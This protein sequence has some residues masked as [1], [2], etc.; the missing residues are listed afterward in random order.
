[1][2]PLGWISGLKAG[3]LKAAGLLAL[4][5]LWGLCS[6]AQVPASLAQ[7]LDQGLDGGQG[8]AAAESAEEGAS[9]GTSAPAAPPAQSVQPDGTMNP[10]WTGLLERLALEG[11]NR[12]ALIPLF[13]NSSLVPDASI[14]GRKLR[15]L[16]K[17]RFLPKPEPKAPTGKPLTIYDTWLTPEWAEKI[18]AFK[19]ANALVLE[20]AARRYGTSPS[21]LTAIFLVETHLGTFLG[22]RPVL[23]ALAN[24]AA[25]TDPG[26]MLPF[27]AE[28]QPTPEQL[29]W[30]AGRQAEKSAW[31]LRQI[32]FF[33]EYCRLNGFA[34]LSLPGSLYGA[35]GLCQFTPLN[36]LRLGVDGD[37]DGR[38]DL[39]G[40]ADAAH[41]MGRFLKSRGWREDLSYQA[42]LKI[43][44]QYNNDLLY[45]QTVLA[46]AKR[47]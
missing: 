26:A 21:L 27:V 13:A 5:V 8:E 18:A 41:S 36:A 3:G 7:G 46:V 10:A 42:K 25:S 2:R 9:P 23:A 14:M 24:L 29:D 32:R 31:A 40:V 12:T 44:R 15:A 30:L 34:P 19:K 35:F 17:S 16:Y 45:A 47:I 1:M 22:Q 28:Y 39:F 6:L 37:G 4:L 43:I 38:V 20:E 33:L 11:E